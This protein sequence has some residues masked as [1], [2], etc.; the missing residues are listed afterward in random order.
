MPWRRLLQPIVWPLYQVYSRLVRG[1]TLG[2]RGLVLNQAGEVLLVEHTYMP[3][4]YLP[5]GGVERGETTEHAVI[6][7]LQEE[8]GVRVIG[9][10][11][12]VTVH[13][14]HRIF[15]GDHVLL[16]RVDHWAP[17]AASQQGEIKAVAWFAPDQL[18]HDIS[19]GS[20]RRIVEALGD[21]EASLHW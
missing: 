10:P 1:V 6:R 19:P 9:R 11:Q 20:R 17:C 12:L 4:W 8:A 18:P 13:A 15:R 5:G 3:G 14:N 2:V 16:Y 21:E 7:E